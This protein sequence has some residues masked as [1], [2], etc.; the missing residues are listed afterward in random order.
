MTRQDL[1][2]VGGEAVVGGDI[3]ELNIGV[4]DGRV[5]MMTS[6]PIDAAETINARGPAG[7]AGRRS[8]STSTRLTA[9]AGRPTREPRAGAVQGGVTTIVD[10]PLDKPATLTADALRTKLEAISGTRHIDYA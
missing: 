5:S 7:D 10:M 3:V 8:T 9:T 4:S 6:E 2:I 1:A